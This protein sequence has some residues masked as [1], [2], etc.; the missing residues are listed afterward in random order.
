MTGERPAG[1]C[2]WALRSILVVATTLTVADGIAHAEPVTPW[3]VA[4]TILPDTSAAPDPVGPP[5]MPAIPGGLGAVMGPGSAPRQGG[6]AQPSAQTPA[7]PRPRLS[8]HPAEQVPSE[9]NRLADMLPALKAAR[10]RPLFSASRRP[11]KPA[12]AAVAQVVAP[13]AA[14]PPT[15]PA[16]R[17]IGIVQDPESA[18]GLVRRG[19]GP[20]L[21]LRTGDMIDGWSVSEIGPAH[22]TIRL[23][24]QVQTHR[25]FAATTP[26]GMRPR[27]MPQQGE[28]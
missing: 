3:G 26:P 16:L 22:L 24:D 10:E 7:L 5:V 8:E 17:L 18:A 6:F 27:P 21:V 2:A 11:Q 13:V 14:P 23:G 20:T 28:R 1:R 25:L 4:R 15:A 9:L 19:S 12:P